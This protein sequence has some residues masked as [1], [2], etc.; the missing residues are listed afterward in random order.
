[1]N[2]AIAS[3]GDGHTNMSVCTQTNG[4]TDT[5]G[6]TGAL[7]RQQTDTNVQSAVGGKMEMYVFILF[8]TWA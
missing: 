8:Y 3:D 2:K 1:M 7:V 5:N 6:Q 4:Q